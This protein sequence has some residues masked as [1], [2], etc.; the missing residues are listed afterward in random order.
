MHNMKK[1]TPELAVNQDWTHNIYGYT[2]RIVS[3]SVNPYNGADMVFFYEAEKE[4]I[5]SLGQGWL[6][7]ITKHC[8]KQW[9]RDNCLNEE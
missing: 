4:E 6:R 1:R 2:R 5:E 8:F 3:F 7:G 9:V